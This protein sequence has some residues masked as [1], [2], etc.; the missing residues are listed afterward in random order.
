[1]AIVL[2][3]SVRIEAHLLFYFLLL[4]DYRPKIISRGGQYRDTKV[5]HYYTFLAPLSV[6][7]VVFQKRT[8]FSFFVTFLACLMRY[9]RVE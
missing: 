8:L 6:P 9:F 2:R 4:Y 5:P 7:L 1:M 3:D